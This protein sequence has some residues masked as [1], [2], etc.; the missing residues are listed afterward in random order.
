MNILKTV[1][2]LMRPLGK[3]EKT[4]WLMPAEMAMVVYAAFTVVLILFTF[5]KVP[6]AE[7]LIWWRIRIVMLTIALWVVYRLW[8]CKLTVLFRVALLLITLSWWY[9]DT[10][11]LN[12][13]FSNLDHIFAGWDQALFGCQPALLWCQNMPSAIVSELMTMGYMMYFPMF[14]GLVFYVFFTRYQDLQRVFF[15]LIASFFVYYVVYDILPVVGPQY[16]Y[17][18]VGLDE[19]A[20]GHF[21]DMGSYFASHSEMIQLPGWENGLFHNL[22]KAT[23]EAGERPT[24]AFPSSHVGVSTLCML[25]AVRLKEWRYIIVC[26]IPYIFLC[27]GTVYLMPHYAVD[28]IAG[29]ISAIAVFFGLEALYVRLWGK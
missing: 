7:A 26:A 24:A 22:L 1:K 27:M 17:V 3:A 4:K 19:I 8:T 20:R 10:Y 18:A 16:Y 29:F 6:N 25:I 23:H 12:R 14:V 28:S 21:P 9:P 15:V 13:H 2:E 5:T 11:L